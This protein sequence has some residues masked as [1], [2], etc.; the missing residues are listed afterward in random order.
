MIEIFTRLGAWVEELFLFDC[1][2]DDSKIFIEWLQ[3]M[4]KLR[5]CIML[6]TST[7][8]LFDDPSEEENLPKFEKLETIE[9]VKSEYR[10]LEYFTTAQVKTLKILDSCDGSLAGLQGLKKFLTTQKSLKTLA[11]R[12]ITADESQLF[13]QPLLPERI[14]FKLQ[15]LSLL[16]FKLRTEPNDHNNLKQFLQVHAR[17]IEELEIG[18]FFPDFIFEFIFSRF[19]K[20]KTLKV[21]TKGIPINDEVY[22]RLDV[23]TSVTKLII[24]D[25][26]QENNEP[27]ENFLVHLPNIESLLI[28]E[29]FDVETMQFIARHCEKLRHL[30]IGEMKKAYEEISFPLL[31]KL[32][33]DYVFDRINWARFTQANPKIK[34]LSIKTIEADMLD[35]GEVTKNLKLRVFRL[36]ANFVT[37]VDFYD[38]ICCNCHDLELLSVHHGSVAI[39]ESETVNVPALKFHADEVFHCTEFASR[40]DGQFWND[41]DYDGKLPEDEL[42][43]LGLGEMDPFDL[44]MM[45]EELGII[46]EF[47]DVD[48]DDEDDF[49]GEVDGFDGYDFAY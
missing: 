43:S 31:E 8:N 11:L 32:H 25:E 39:D 48:D 19:K 36:G 15:K 16:G 40:K 21:S 46:D 27:L 3:T 33:I 47:E 28:S 37:D 5:K 10:L 35:I 12:S 44:H 38:A 17:S 20:L 34:D 49:D 42:E 41:D 4:P 24:E 18:R 29:E 7:L 13:K 14:P 30:V 26:T 45:L 22:E 2:F 23:N 1:V 9:M 6:E